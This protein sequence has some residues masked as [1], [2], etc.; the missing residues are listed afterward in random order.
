MLGL[1]SGLSLHSH[2]CP[3]FL[4]QSG[5]DP[6]TARAPMGSRVPW[7]QGGGTKSPCTSSWRCYPCPSEGPVLLDVLSA[8]CWSPGHCLCPAPIHPCPAPLPTPGPSVWLR[9]LAIALSELP[10][11]MP[12]LWLSHG[13]PPCLWGPSWGPLPPSLTEGLRGP[14]HGW[15]QP[16]EG[17]LNGGVPPP[18]LLAQQA[19]LLRC[20]RGSNA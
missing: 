8:P 9:G 10:R 5:L 12:P 20:G 14:S 16:G 11:H 7:V 1:T 13:C 19:A 17:Q 6:L 18:R 3:P 4:F 2:P 15:L